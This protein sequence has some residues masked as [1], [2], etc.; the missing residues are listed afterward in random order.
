MGTERRTVNTSELP[1]DAAGK[2][3]ED[4]YAELDDAPA[5][6]RVLSGESLRKWLD[7]PTT[8]EENKTRIAKYKAQ[9]AAHYARVASG[10]NDLEIEAVEQRRQ[11]R[12]APPRLSRH[13]S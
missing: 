6:F 9:D 13:I 10:E 5:R 1:R 11:E 4:Y 8:A 2:N 12:A 7:V 3:A